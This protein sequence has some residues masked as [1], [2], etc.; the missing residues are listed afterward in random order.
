MDKLL[1]ALVAQPMKPSMPATHHRLHMEA[2]R[3]YHLLSILAMRAIAERG[4]W[5]R[6]HRLVLK[7]AARQARR[8]V[9]KPC[10][11]CGKPAY[12]H[13]IVGGELLGA[14]PAHNAT[15]RLLDESAL[16]SEAA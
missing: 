3:T 1:L 13:Y 2:V 5:K 10:H 9:N 4:D 6:M 14:C 12:T 8:F 7:A 16:E 11:L 15:M